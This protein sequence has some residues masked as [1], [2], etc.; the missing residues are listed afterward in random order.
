MGEDVISLVHAAVTGRIYNGVGSRPEY[1][2]VLIGVVLALRNMEG[3]RLGRH[4]GKVAALLAAV[5]IAAPL[6][7]PAAPGNDA[8]TLADSV[9]RPFDQAEIRRLV[10]D[11]KTVLVDVTADWCLTCQ[12]NKAAVLNRDPVA[13]ILESGEVVEGPGFSFKVVKTKTQSLPNG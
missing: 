5:I 7:A 13:G 8:Q 4:A 9:W 12:V 2:P 1:K 10:A 6:F 11:G 3:L